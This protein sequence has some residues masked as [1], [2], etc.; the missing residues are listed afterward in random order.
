MLAR[1]GL[2]FEP[3]A[4]AEPCC[5]IMP[6]TL[7]KIEVIARRVEMGQPLFVPGDPTI[8][9]MSQMSAVLESMSGSDTRGLFR[10]TVD[11]DDEED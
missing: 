9:R 3:I 5:G 1:L 11:D 8:F 7:E 4:D 2:S 6:G 10:T